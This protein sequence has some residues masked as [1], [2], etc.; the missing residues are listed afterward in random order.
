MEVVQK[1]TPTSI[2]VVVV[3][4]LNQ[5]YV[6]RLSQEQ[7]ETVITQFGLVWKRPRGQSDS[8]KTVMESE[9]TEEK[10]N[11]NGAT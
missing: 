6:A 9:Q 10:E 11:N 1:I 2:R 4:S 7:L 3:S 8:L 5:M